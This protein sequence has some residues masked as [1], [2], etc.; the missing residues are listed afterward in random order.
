MKK[1]MWGI[2][3]T[4]NIAHTFATTLSRLDESQLYAVYSRTES[5]GKD[6]A[7]K[8]SVSKVYSSLDDFLKDENITT[9]YIATPHSNHAEISVKAMMNGKNVLCEK[10]CAVNQKQLEEV[11]KIAE[12][13][14][15]FFMEA[16]WSKCNPVFLATLEWIKQGRIGKLTS[17][18]ADFCNKEN[19]D[20][21]S[22]LFDPNTAGGA[23]LDLGYYVVGITLAVTKQ[24]GFEKPSSLNSIAHIEK[25]IDLSNSIQ[26]GFNNNDIIAHLS[27]SLEGMADNFLHDVYFIGTDGYIRMNEIWCSRESFLYNGNGKLIDSIEHQFEIN[28]YEYE[29]REVN[30]CV[31]IGA[32]ESQFH[33]H[34]DTKT[35]ISILEEIRKQWNLIYPFEKENPSEVK[36]VSQNRKTVN[37]MPLIIY[38]DGGCHGNPG[39]GGWGFVIKDDD[40]QLEGSG[41]A[42]GTTNNKMELKAVIEA[43]TAVENKP[44]WNER[45][46]VINIDSQYVKNGITQW[47]KNWKKNNWKT[48]SKEPVKNQELWIIL[49]ALVQK[50]EIEWQWVKGHSGVEYN[51]IVDSL[52]QIEIAKL[53]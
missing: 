50:H 5:K 13:K 49:D 41:G 14:N 29:V 31:S 20:K 16:F 30:R 9:V 7:E 3:G 27:S 2:I 51:E 4:G 53:E 42:A 44:E 11:L 39:P 36:K 38:T 32:K 22:R 45:K 52:T 28:G 21:S 40:V 48:A 26:M 46:I 43:L 12:E 47:I 23:L 37:S 34:R 1:N 18:R 35:V 8:F 15:V 17:I 19:Y 24:L 33:T 10:P 25:G 6:F